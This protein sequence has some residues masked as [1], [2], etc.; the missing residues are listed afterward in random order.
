MQCENGYIFLNPTDTSLTLCTKFIAIMVSSL[1]M[2]RLKTGLKTLHKKCTQGMKGRLFRRTE[3]D[4][5]GSSPTAMKLSDQ[6][7]VSC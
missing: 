2:E 1:K 5:K 7:S 6:C 3:V 4:K